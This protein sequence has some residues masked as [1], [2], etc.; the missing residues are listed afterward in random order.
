MS[1]FSYPIAIL[2]FTLGYSASV[3]ATAI[4]V[5]DARGV[6]GSATA[7]SGGVD[8]SD[9]QSDS[10]VPTFSD[11]VGIIGFD[12][13]RGGAS[14]GLSATQGSSVSDSL[15]SGSGLV[16]ANADVLTL[17]FDESAGATADSFF[18]IFFT[19]SE[20]HDYTLSLILAAGPA[21][22]GGATQASFDLF[23]PVAVSFLAVNA[24]TVNINQPGILLAGDYRFLAQANVTAMASVSSEVESALA[25]AL[26][27]FRFEF[28]P[29]TAPVPE[30]MAV[31]FLGLGAAVSLLK[32]RAAR[33]GSRPS[34]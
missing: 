2:L 28:T 13:S 22:P 31:W 6:E 18:D 17:N 32:G 26:Y 24:G 20:P 5:T 33:T 11:F 16:S 19:L 15:F 25:E 7:F 8:V 12:R 3:D 34:R 29:I 27:S 4:L 14:S 10:P 30:P 21:G 23:G 1:R 9:S